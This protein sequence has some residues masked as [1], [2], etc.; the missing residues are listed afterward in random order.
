MKYRFYIESGS[1]NLIFST[2]DIIEAIFSA[3]NCNGDLWEVPKGTKLYDCEYRWFSIRP[4]Y[5]VIDCD[6]LYCNADKILHRY[7]VT[8]KS[9]QYDEDG[10]ADGE[11]IIIDKNGKE[12]KFGDTKLR[13]LR[14]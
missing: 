8:I 7:G 3:Y 6:D 9:S 4:T 2:N 12:W 1:S 10:E 11:L 5:M 13:K 14:E